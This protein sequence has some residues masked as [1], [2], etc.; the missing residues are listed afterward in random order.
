MDTMSRARFAVHVSVVLALVALVSGPEQRRL[1]ASPFW[2]Y[3]PMLTAEPTTA[4]GDPRFPAEPFDGRQG[5]IGFGTVSYVSAPAVPGIP[6]L[7]QKLSE[8]VYENRRSLLS[9]ELLALGAR[10][11][12]ILGYT[13]TS[14]NEAI[15]FARLWLRNVRTG[16]I[17]A[18]AVADQFGQF[19]FLDIH[20][21]GYVVELIGP[22]GTVMAASALLSIRT[23]ELRHTTL[24]VPLGDPRGA[25]LTAT[26]GAP[27]MI[28]TAADEGVS[29]VGQPE[30]G[31]SPQR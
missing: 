4:G 31:V 11:N 2:G 16:E 30:R 26:A 17:E 24:F 8:N 13:R 23:G 22:D 12:A 3:G 21:S 28:D 15:P 5:Q 19:L 10:I 9:P 18:R 20:P 27:R 7:E 25:R 29:R 6:S 14:T 1:R